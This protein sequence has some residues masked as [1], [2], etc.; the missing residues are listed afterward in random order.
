[1][2]A[3]ELLAAHAALVKQYAEVDKDHSD[4][5]PAQRAG[6]RAGIARK[7]TREIEI[8]L[9][10]ANVTYEPFAP[11]RK[12]TVR[13]SRT[14]ADLLARLD[15]LS[16]LANDESRRPAIRAVAQSEADRLRKMAVSRSLIENDSAD[17]K[18]KSTAKP[19]TTTVKSAAKRAPKK[20]AGAVKTEAT[21]P[22]AA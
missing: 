9:E 18:A 3:K 1:M 5:T 16:Q 14:D 21:F 13:H 7:I 11:E 17:A 19:K 6:I 10:L 22:T 4:K 2:T 12:S 15:T 20:I 8:E